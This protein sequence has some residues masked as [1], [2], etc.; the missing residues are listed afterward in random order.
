M[1]EQITSRASSVV[2]FRV[3]RLRRSLKNGPT[4]AALAVVEQYASDGLTEAQYLLAQIL[5]ESEQ[6]DDVEAAKR[7]YE[8]AARKGHVE[9]CKALWRVTAINTGAGAI[10]RSLGF[11]IRAAPIWA[12]TKQAAF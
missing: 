7:W 3:E 9:A 6:P 4:P 5:A 8:A 1:T 10:E 12:T 11:I 2:D